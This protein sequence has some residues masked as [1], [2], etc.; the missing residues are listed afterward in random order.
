MLRYASKRNICCR[1]IQ[2]RLTVLPSSWSSGEWRSAGSYAAWCVMATDVMWKFSL[3]ARLRSSSASNARWIICCCCLRR[4]VVAVT[5]DFCMKTTSNLINSIQP[6]S[7]WT[8]M[9]TSN[10][11]HSQSQSPLEKPG[12]R[13][14]KVPIYCKMV[15]STTGNPTSTAWAPQ[16]FSSPHSGNAW[17]PFCLLV[18]TLT[19]VGSA[20]ESLS[21]AFVHVRLQLKLRWL[22]WKEQLM[23]LS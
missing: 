3:A 4:V 7:Y 12:C 18:I 6:F 9:V 8:S 14:A 16:S 1:C 5:K 2:N 21:G 17:S 22:R 11:I 20:S 19:S 23:I 15:E 13:N 10:E